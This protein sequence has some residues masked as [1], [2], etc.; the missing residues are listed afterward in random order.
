MYNKNTIIQKQSQIWA[1]VFQ[2]VLDGIVWCDGMHSAS[3][4]CV[5]TQGWNEDNRITNQWALLKAPDSL[6]IWF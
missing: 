6:C 2:A 1:E 4:H 5:Q 3:G